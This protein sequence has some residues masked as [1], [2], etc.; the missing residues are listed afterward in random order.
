VII[1]IGLGATGNQLF[2][3][4]LGAVAACLVVVSAGVLLRR[5]LSSVPE[6]LLKFIVGVMVSAFG[7]FWFGEGIG[8][9]WPH[10]DFAIVG[11][12]AILLATSAAGVSIAHRIHARQGS[13]Q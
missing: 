9:S 2:P 1:V 11:L 6:N 4:S 13:G 12:M 8:V 5:P 10:A 7:L 3:A